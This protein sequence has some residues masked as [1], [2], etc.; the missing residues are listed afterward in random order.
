MPQAEPFYLTT[1]IYYVN[2]RPHLGHVFA[3]VVA[4]AAIRLQ[5]LRGRDAFL[6]SGTDEHAAKVV[7]TGRENGMSAQQWADRNAAIFRETLERFDISIDDF[8]RTSAPAHC[9]FA[10]GLVRDLATTDD[11]Y[12]GEYEGW[13]D[14]GEEEYVPETRAKECDYKSPVS[15]RPLVRR[16]E[17]NYFFRLSAYQERLLELLEE[18]PEYVLPAQRRNEVI[19][20]IQQGLHDVPIS[21]STGSDWGVPFPDAPGHL[22]YVWVEAL[23]SYVTPIEQ[24][25]RR[26]WPAHVH[27]IGKDILW[28]HAVIWPCLLMA[29]QKVPGR[30]WLELPGTIY[31]HSWWTSEGQKMSKSL[32]NFIDLEALEGYCDSFGL[33]AL[34]W[35]LLTQGPLGT[36]DGDFSEAR[37][38]EVYNADLANTVGNCFSRIVNMTHRF[39]SGRLP[40]VAAGE[41][42]EHV[43]AVLSAPADAADPLALSELGRGLELVRRIDAYIEATQPFKLAK[44]SG[45]ERRVGEILY[46]CA[47]AYRIASLRLWPAMPRRMEE[48]WRRL[49]CD[50]YGARLADRGRG[51]LS[52]WSRW[53][54]LPEGTELLKGDALFPRYE[55]R[56]GKS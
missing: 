43:E 26:Y 34:R 25:Q 1:P 32:G 38:I 50:E 21:R 17:A 16:K 4:D 36:Q 12:L 40:V 42:Q 10:Q 9:A 30:E 44:Q 48:V 2:D 22:V 3:S 56:G 51:D 8:I 35:F 19:G 46:A 24:D 15:G 18:R 31:A 6:L 14:S 49:G 27:L 29:L 39:L 5:R 52:A 41:L 13:Y 7:E 23:M 11:V 37:F 45:Q 55:A 54:G 28:F 33:D 20:R 47:E 53:G